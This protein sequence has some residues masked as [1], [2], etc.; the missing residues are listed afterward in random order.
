MITRRVRTGVGLL[1]AVVAVPLVGS[2]AGREQT[3]ASAVR[4]LGQ[5]PP[6]TTPVRFAP[7][8]VSTDAIEINAAFRPD[9]REFFFA[10]HV[11]G[12]FTLFYSTLTGSVWSAPAPLPV[13]PGGATGVAVDM[14]YSPD[15]R[16]LFFLGRFKPGVPPLEAPTDI[17]VTR[18]SAQG[19]STAELVPDPVSTDASEV[20]PIVVADGSLYFT[21][22][23]PGGH[24]GSDI[25]R[26]A[27]GAD[28]RFRTVVN[29]GSPP[30]SRDAEGDTFV[31]P[32]ERYLIFSS[33]REG[34]AGFGD[35]YVSFR[36][37]DNHW[38]PPISLDALNTAD[39][40]FCPMVTPDGRYLFFSRRYG[41][42]TWPTTTQ[43]DV[44]WVDLAV[45]ERARRDPAVRGLTAPAR[46]TSESRN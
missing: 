33:R 24:G 19:W 22:D 45:V 39:H 2:G 14:A 4:Y 26:A 28:G 8:I 3:V 46:A 38:G 13:F 17:W 12:I 41:G 11:D 16:E 5:T 29:I 34:N 43:A 7:G 10:R 44:F 30:N 42:G 31:S 40:E 32:D 27:R 6:G 23:R 25:Y 15:G 9:F 35:L 20:Y 37:P 36:T 21:S 1:L 18:R